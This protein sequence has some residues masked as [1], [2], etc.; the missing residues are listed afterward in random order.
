MPVRYPSFV[1]SSDGESR[2]AARPPVECG[3]DL[4]P[5]AQGRDPGEIIDHP[6][7]CRFHASFLPVT[8]EVGRPL[9]W[10]LEPMG[11]P[12]LGSQGT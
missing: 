6:F 3:C 10:R 8:Y 9:G 12:S 1:R 2:A 11:H 4:Q 7:T 5:R